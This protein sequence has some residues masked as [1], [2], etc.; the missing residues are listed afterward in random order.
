MQSCLVWREL[1]KGDWMALCWVNICVWL[2]GKWGGGGDTIS[3]NQ[4]SKL[5]IL[6]HSIVHCR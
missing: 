3:F 5:N 6:V 1:S 2:V 4:N